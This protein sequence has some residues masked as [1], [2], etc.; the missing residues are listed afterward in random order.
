MTSTLVAPVR[1]LLRP[2]L[3]RVHYEPE[4]GAPRTAPPR[5]GPPAAPPPAAPPPPA[6][7]AP[8]LLAPALLATAPAATAHPTTAHPTTA[9]PTTADLAEAHRA[10]THVLRLALEVFDGRRPLAHLAGHVE[11]SVLR[12]WRA[13]T[14]QRRVRAPARFS[15]IRLCLPRSSI[16]EVA[17][18][19]DVDGRPRAVAARFERR[20]AGWRCT[21]LRLG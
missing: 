8:A 5:A 4:P 13:A 19:C 18:T 7:L 1:P 10:V 11:P 3:R 15:R 14:Q 21:T 12:Y 2:R 17:V 20:R 16:A 6:L 9:D